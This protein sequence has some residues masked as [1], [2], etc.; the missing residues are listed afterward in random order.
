MGLHQHGS[1]L[2][3]N[4]FNE[5]DDSMLQRHSDVMHLPYQQQWKDAKVIVKRPE[6]DLSQMEYFTPKLY[7]QM[8]GFY[9]GE[10][11]FSKAGDKWKENIEKYQK[12]MG[13]MPDWIQDFSSRAY[14]LH[15]SVV[16]VLEY[17][18]NDP[19]DNRLEGMRIRLTPNRNHAIGPQIFEVRAVW[20]NKKQVFPTE[21]RGLSP[22]W[23]Y[24]EFSV[25]KVSLG[26]EEYSFN[27]FS[28]DGCEHNF[29]GI[30]SI[31]F[32]PENPE[33]VL[34]SPAERVV[35]RKKRKK[36][37]KGHGVKSKR[38][39]TCMFRDEMSDLY[40]QQIKSKDWTTVW[41]DFQ[42]TIQKS[43]PELAEKK[44]GYEPSLYPVSLVIR[45]AYAGKMIIEEEECEV[46]IINTKQGCPP[47]TEEWDAGTPVCR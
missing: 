34:V 24:D 11:D 35:P 28:T 7:A 40:F 18:P 21:F 15:N 37:K 17:I 1:F 8:N 39:F 5:P 26:V 41:L 22:T 45:N 44:I 12:F 29:E 4:D 30:V 20:C 33:E 16:E 10:P 9:T 23:C 42:A 31:D 3:E 43:L 19:E 46:Y 27:F 2:G 38:L 6:C 32:K 25:N 13:E 14:W 47:G 36:R